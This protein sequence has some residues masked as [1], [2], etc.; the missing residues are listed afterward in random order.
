MTDP[1]EPFETDTPVEGLTS[2]DLDDARMAER[3]SADLETGVG[4]TG[5]AEGSG[6]TADLDVAT[7]DADVPPAI[8]DGD[9]ATLAAESEAAESDAATSDGP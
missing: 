4:E 2:T 9:P 5:A 3:G 8:E 6:D 1:R 7:A